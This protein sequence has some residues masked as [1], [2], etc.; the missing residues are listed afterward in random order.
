VVARGLLAGLV[1]VPVALASRTAQACSAPNPQ[2]VGITVI[3]RDGATEVSTATSF[4]VASPTQPTGIG[5]EVPLSASIAV[6][7]PTAIGSGEDETTHAPVVYWLVRPVANF[8]PASSEIKLSMD[9]G[10]GGTWVS[11]IHTAAGY[12]KQQGTAAVIKSL[13]LTRVRYPVSEIASGNCVFAEYVGFASFESD[14]AAVPGTPADSVVNAIELAPKTGG[15]ATQ[16]RAFTGQAPYSG[17]AA[18]NVNSVGAWYPYLDPTL[19]YCATIRSFGY[20]DRARQPLV[21]NTVCA[22]VTETPSPSLAN[23]GGTDAITV[24]ASI[25]AGASDATCATPDGRPVEDSITPPAKSGCS[26]AG[27]S[28]ES[29]SALGTCLALCLVAGA[30]LRP[31][32]REAA[33][34]RAARGRR[35]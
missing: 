1:L 29:L 22:H 32:A 23:D 9:D 31:R 2:F 5:L 16:V 7:A 6:S 27:T 21:S 11:T 35:S 18:G 34:S 26:A 13:K 30:A 33:F 3:P 28:T 17:T 20:G 12:D 19:E 15:A 14:P 4:V 8:L 10:K 24:D 25:D